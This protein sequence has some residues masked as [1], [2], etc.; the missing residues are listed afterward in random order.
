MKINNPVIRELVVTAIQYAIISSMCIWIGYSMRGSYNQ[1]EL[2]QASREEFTRAIGWAISENILI[3][4]TNA[5]QKFSDILDSKM[6]ESDIANDEDLSNE[7]ENAELP[8][9]F[10]NVDVG[11]ETNAMPPSKSIQK[12]KNPLDTTAII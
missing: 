5:L 2:K 11:V 12:S 4:N 10:Q 7:L 3:V 9:I 1:K 8:E 6:D